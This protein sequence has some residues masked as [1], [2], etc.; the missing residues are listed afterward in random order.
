MWA[1]QDRTGSSAEIG[2]LRRFGGRVRCPFC[3]HTGFQGLGKSMHTCWASSGMCGPGVLVSAGLEKQ[4]AAW[5]VR[6]ATKAMAVV[7]LHGDVL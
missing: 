2:H 4:P 5:L 7:T 6:K 1:G 3:G